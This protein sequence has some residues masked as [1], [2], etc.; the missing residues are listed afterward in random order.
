MLRFFSASTCIVN[1]KK[2]I[3]KCIENALEGEENLNCDLLIINTAMGH[4]FKELLN[5]AKK[6]SPGARI[7]GCSCSGIIGKEGPEESMKALAIMAIKCDKNDFVI[8]GMNS[9]D[10]LDAHLVG[11]QLATELMNQNPKI[12]MVLCY[13]TLAL[14]KFDKFI[15]GVDSVFWGKVPLFGGAAND[16]MR[17]ISDFEFLDDQV[18]E[19]GVVM[20]G[21]VDPTLELIGMANHGLEVI[22][23]PFKVTENMDN[24]IYKLDGEPAW[25]AW[26]NKLGLPE[27]TS[28]AEVKFANLAKKTPYECHKEYGSEY[29]IRVGA[30]HTPDGSIVS[31]VSC[32]PGTKLWI[33]RRNEDLMIEGVDQMLTQ[34]LEKCAKRKPLAVF[35]ADCIV[36]GKLTF[37]KIMKDEIVRH[38]Q[39]PLCKNEEIPWLGMYGGGEFTPLGGKNQMHSYTTTLNVLVRR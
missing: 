9:V 15:E 17:F 36:R 23:D 35:H 16:G 34:I 10:N 18:F 8:A 30:Y 21:I 20:L 12:N 31:T 24:I 13:A 3:T 32:K 14:N 4:N 26:M 7:I 5:E 19:R 33:T 25:K 27:T 28:I 2:A 22:G 38:I 1:S 6:I 11:R 29:I 37:D 39:Y